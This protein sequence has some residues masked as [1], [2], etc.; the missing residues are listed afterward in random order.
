M[1]DVAAVR[2]R[3]QSRRSSTTTASRVSATGA[4]LHASDKMPAFLAPYRK[5]SET[6][7]KTK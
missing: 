7:D 5:G 6:E 4:G 2:I 1:S 3:A